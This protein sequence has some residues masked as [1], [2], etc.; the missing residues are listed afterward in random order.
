VIVFP[1]YKKRTDE[2]GRRIPIIRLKP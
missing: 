2:I 1:A